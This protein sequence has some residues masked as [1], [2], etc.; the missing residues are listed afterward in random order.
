VKSSRQQ[1]IPVSIIEEFSRRLPKHKIT[2]LAFNSA[3][4]VRANST[5]CVVI[6]PVD[7]ETMRKATSF[8]GKAVATP[9]RV[10]DV[11]E[12]HDQPI[13]QSCTRSLL[14]P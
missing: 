5:S 11:G 3:A 10:V 14:Y 7:L 6:A 4:V 13:N 2:H 8:C 12:Q 1:A 9:T